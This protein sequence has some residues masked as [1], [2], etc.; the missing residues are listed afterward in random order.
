VKDK[1][2]NEHYPEIYKVHYYT[3]SGIKLSFNFGWICL[4]EY[5]AHAVQNKFV[6]GTDHSDVPYVAPELI[7]HKEYP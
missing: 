5:V 7:I 4:T 6:P 3:R 2:G 1:E